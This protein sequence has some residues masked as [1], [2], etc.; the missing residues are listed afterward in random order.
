METTENAEATTAE[1][2]VRLSALLEAAQRAYPEQ[3][4]GPAEKWWLPAHLGG[5]AP[6]PAPVLA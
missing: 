1:L 5:T 2:R 4:S 3:P 6:L